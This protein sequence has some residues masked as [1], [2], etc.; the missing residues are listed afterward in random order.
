[1]KTKRLIIFARI[2]SIIMIIC[3]AFLCFGCMG[4]TPDDNDEDLGEIEGEIGDGDDSIFD[5][6]LSVDLYG[7]KVLY[8][9]DEYDFSTSAGGTKENPKD[10]YGE[11]AWWIMKALVDIY[12]FADSSKIP[13]YTSSYIQLG[14]YSFFYDNIR[15][16]IDAVAE[17]TKTK[18][19]DASGNETTSDLS[20]ENQYILIRYNP[21]QSWNM[22]FDYDLSGY[23]NAY[24]SLLFTNQ[25]YTESATKVY[26]AFDSISKYTQSATEKY[27]EIKT[28]YYST[29]LGSTSATDESNYSDYV[30]A[31]QYAIYSY[32]LNTTPGKLEVTMEDKAT[33]STQK[34]YSLSITEEDTN[35]TPTTLA[36]DDA[37]ANI[38]AKFQ[39]LG[40]FVGLTEN[41]MSKIADWVKTNVVGH[42]TKVLNDN[43]FRYYDV[44]EVKTTDSSGKV[45]LSY[46]FDLNN[47]SANPFGR[48][49]ANATNLIVNAMADKVSIG[50]DG[51]NARTI[52]NR[53]LA[54]EMIEYAGD[55]FM[56]AGDENFPKYTE[57]QSSTAIRPLEYQS[58]IIMP[59]K[60]ISFS[61]IWIAL[62]Y[63]ADLDG[64]SNGIY[65][66]KYLDIIV[67]LNYFSFQ[68]QKVFKIG[69]QQTRVYD[70]P[71]A[72]SPS[73]FDYDHGTLFFDSFSSF[74]KDSQFKSLL[75]EGSLT[76][77]K[78]N[79]SIGNNALI[80]DVGASGY[81]GLPLVSKSPLTIVGT[82]TIKDFYSIVEPKEN[83]LSNL[84]QTYS[85]GMAN[86]EKFKG[87][88]GCDYLEITYKVLKT[89]GDTNTNYKF[90]TGIAA[91]L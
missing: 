75:D 44:T 52:D 6:L 36:I 28:F 1:M 89:K 72:L 49:Y 19:I 14:E 5:D 85:T 88:D 22:T 17:V 34:L 21:N 91:I 56:I 10:Y 9:P 4:R 13:L 41:Q 43:F 80:T 77:G 32:A 68:K 38:K 45:T 58:V 3:F 79:T 70:G 81:A 53:F 86:A 60:E 55:T 27:E 25:V 71:Y 74:C 2:F 57:G 15:H 87:N 8:R 54:S 12:G 78:F 61:D 20:S 26:S 82:S 62:K 24:N 50:T 7:T 64:T 90:Y 51:E 42:Q 84:N 29:M 83:E 76:I 69:S 65:G 59:K 18:T 39:K 30:K 48:N 35:G 16:K 47:Y 67:E 73:G 33:T 11:Y 23:N 37:L 66:T 63:D 31:L 40:T 46:E